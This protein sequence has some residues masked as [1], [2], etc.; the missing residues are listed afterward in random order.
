MNCAFIVLPMLRSVLR[1][2]YNRSTQDQTTASRLLRNVLLFVPVDFSI[3]IHRMI[4]G[5]IFVGFVGHTSKRTDR[6]H[7]HKHITSLLTPHS[8]LQMVSLPPAQ[9]WREACADHR[10]DGLVANHLRHPAALRRL[11]HVCRCI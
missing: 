4:A 9:L 10:G 8:L 11:H 6:L 7:A 5:Y 3:A 1:W 2:L